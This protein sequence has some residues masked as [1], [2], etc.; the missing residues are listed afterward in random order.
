MSVEVLDDD[1]VDDRRE[2][3]AVSEP[4][5]L[6]TEADITP[7]GIS[8]D[9]DNEIDLRVRDETNDQRFRIDGGKHMLLAT[10][11]GRH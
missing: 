5:V 8:L 1:A 7:D 11:P 6:E 3:E 2:K 9:G 4:V 10:P